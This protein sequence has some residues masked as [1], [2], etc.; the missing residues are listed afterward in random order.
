M[1]TEINISMDNSFLNEEND[2]NF[3]NYSKLNKKINP[4]LNFDEKLKLDFV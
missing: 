2:N 1:K 4:K 3:N